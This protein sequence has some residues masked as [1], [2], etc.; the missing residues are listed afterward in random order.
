[1]INNSLKPSQKLEE[2]VDYYK[3]SQEEL[4][5]SFEKTNI[6]SYL[7]KLKQEDKDY[8]ILLLPKK[9]SL[10]QINSIIKESN[11]ISVSTTPIFY[12]DSINFFQRLVDAEKYNKYEKSLKQ[13]SYPQIQQML[14]LNLIER[15]FYFDKYKQEMPLKYF[16]PETKNLSKGTRNFKFGLVWLEYSHI[17][18]ISKNNFKVENKFSKTYCLPKE[19]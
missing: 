5:N 17:N 15:F 1:M 2:M 13:Y 11:K 3:T 18:N 14:K 7:F 16:Q 19:R 10:T 6:S 12:K 8:S 4:G 9:I